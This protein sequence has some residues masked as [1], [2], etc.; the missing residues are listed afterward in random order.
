VKVTG[1]WLTNPATQK[2]M[3]MLAGG[4]YQAFAVGGCVRNALLGIAVNDVDIA[5]NAHPQDVL[6]LAKKSGLKAVPTGIEHGTITVV[7]NNI[8]FEVTTFR[9]DIETDGRRAVVAFAETLDEDAHRRDFTVNALYADQAGT[10][11][12]PLGGLADITARKIRFIDNASD[13]IHEDYLRILRFFRFHAW[14]G[15]AD[16][17]IDADGL[18]AC[19]ELADGIESLSKER[20]GHEVLKLLAADDPAPSLATMEISGILARV[21]PGASAMTVAPLIHFE[22]EMGIVPDALRRLAAMG[23]QDPVQNLRLSKADQRQLAALSVSIASP[24]SLPELAY[25]LGA[26]AARDIALLRAAILQTAVSDELL[27]SLDAT[28]EQKFPIT[29]SDLDAKFQGAALGARLKKLESD[30]IASGFKLTKNQ[31]LS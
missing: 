7:C 8:G 21:L 15:N 17:G 26:K 28:S 11:I 25:R 19:A 24:A 9:K 22:Q 2:V 5:T 23:G 3:S 4:G 30:W 31:L 10:V 27:R 13:R 6:A 12:D 14:Y 18:A 1:P 16:A 20:I 29:A